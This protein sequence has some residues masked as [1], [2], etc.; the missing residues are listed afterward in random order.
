[1]TDLCSHPLDDSCSS[2][3]KQAKYRG[4]QRPIDRKKSLANKRYYRANSYRLK[5]KR[6]LRYMRKRNAYSRGE[7]GGHEKETLYTRKR[8]RSRR[9]GVNSK[10]VG[11]INYSAMGGRPVTQKVR[12]DKK[13]Q[14]GVSGKVKKVKPA[15][16]SKNGR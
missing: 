10:L 7:V 14:L 11:A 3:E 13:T 9:K 2:S 5:L 12:T 4:A 6:R 8:W 15:G 16:R 1:M